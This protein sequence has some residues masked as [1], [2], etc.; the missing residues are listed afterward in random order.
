M[1][2]LVTGLDRSRWE[3]CVFCLSGEGVLAE[4]LSR[5]GV[6][7]TCLG[8]KSARSLSVLFRLAR[9]L[10]DFRPALLQTYLYHANITGRIAGRMARVPVIVSG[11]RVA[12][13]RSRLRLWFD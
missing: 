1:V 10:R 12:E 9:A 2:Q 4:V 5:S 13:Q 3:P 11:I 7:V 6:R 8:A